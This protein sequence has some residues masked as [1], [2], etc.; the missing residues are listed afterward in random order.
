MQYRLIAFLKLIRLPNLVM[1]GLVQLFLAISFLPAF[2]PEFEFEIWKI[3]SLIFSIVFLAAGGNLINAYYDQK[4]DLINKVKYYSYFKQLGRKSCLYLYGLLSMLGLCFGFYLFKLNT[5]LSIFLIFLLV[6]FSLFVY[7]KYLKG[8]FLYGNLLVS[9]LV[10]LSIFLPW[11]IWVKED[12]FKLE[13]SVLQLFLFYV[14]FSILTNFARELV[15][16][17]EDVIG[18]YAT[19]LKTLPILLGKKRTNT[20]IQLV[21]FLVLIGLVLVYFQFFNGQL[22][23]LLY[24]FLV[25]VSLGIFIFFKTG[26]ANHKKDYSNLSIWFKVWMLLGLISL[27]FY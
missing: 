27:G 5:D 14:G 10:G 18:D 16:D 25:L 3:V 9:S 1:L 12:Q 22:F 20:I 2:I 7:S 19:E 4:T 21:T 17:A 8:I 11:L 6:F 24:I 13:D 15:K 26:K 23:P